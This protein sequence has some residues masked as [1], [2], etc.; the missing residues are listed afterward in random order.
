MEH[1]LVALKFGRKLGTALD[2]VFQPLA[3]PTAFDG[4]SAWSSEGQ[5]RV[6]ISN[7]GRRVG[8][9]VRLLLRLPSSDVVRLRD[10]KQSLSNIDSLYPGRQARQFTNDTGV[11]HPG[12][13]TSVV[14]VGISFLKAFF[15][16]NTE[17][18]FLHWTLFADE[19][20]PREG[21]ASL[22]DLSWV[23]KKGTE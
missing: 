5:V 11:F 14:E 2:L 10:M 18:A 1:D 21:E 17:E 3:A 12:M 13:N 22:M 4:E 15:E 6:L 23:T 16:A 8:R 20:S 7:A 9:H 19:M